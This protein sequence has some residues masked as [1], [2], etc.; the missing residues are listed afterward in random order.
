MKD[1]RMI[2]RFYLEVE[3]VVWQA[4]FSNE[5]MEKSEKTETTLRIF[6]RNFIHFLR[7]FPLSL[8]SA[9]VSKRKTDQI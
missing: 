8:A 7:T 3:L 4:E 1:K 9:S 6:F 5:T 2:C